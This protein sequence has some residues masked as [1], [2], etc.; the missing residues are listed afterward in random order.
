MQFFVGT[1]F[2]QVLVVI[3]VLSL[4][5]IFA[6]IINKLIKAKFPQHPKIIHMTKTQRVLA[7]H[8][9]TALIYL[10]GI[11]AAI[12]IVPSLRTLSISIFASAGVLAI[13]VGFASQ[14]AIA[15]V[16]GGVFIAVFVPFRIGDLIKIKDDM[17]FVEDITL[18]HTILKNFENQRIIIP[19]STITNETLT[20]YTITDE[21]VCVFLE[22]DISYDSDYNLAKKIMIEEASKH[23]DFLDVRTISEMKSKVPKVKVKLLKFTDSS[24]HLRAWVWAKDPAKAFHMKWDLH[25]RIKARFD[26]EGV[27]IPFPHRTIVMKK[28]MKKTRKMKKPSAKKVTA[29]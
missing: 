3:L 5:H 18:R 9:V 23:K 2:G 24:Q 14:Q 22:M 6:T 16:I 15:Q 10:I 11:G 21:K 7:Q 1:A 28:D 13:V 8:F 29:K 12:Y 25:E 27:S 4:T 17:G 19:N 20:N 26:K